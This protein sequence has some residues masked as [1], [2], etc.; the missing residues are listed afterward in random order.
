MWLKCRNQGGRHSRLMELKGPEV[1]GCLTCGNGVHEQ[2]WV[3]NMA[4]GHRVGGWDRGLRGIM[5]VVSTAVV[6]KLCPTLLLPHG[7]EPAVRGISQGK[8]TGV[9]DCH[10]LFQGIFP[11]QGLNLHLLHCR[12]ILYH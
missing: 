12:Q 5:T 2:N 9:E 11:T 3:A 7:L 4:E 1:G 10:S 6:A 8:N